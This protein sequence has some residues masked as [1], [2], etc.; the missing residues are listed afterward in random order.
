MQNFRK[1]AKLRCHE[2]CEPQ[3]REINVSRK[4][5]VIRYINHIINQAHCPRFQTIPE[6]QALKSEGWE[7]VSNLGFVIQQQ[8]IPTNLIK[9]IKRAYPIM[10]LDKS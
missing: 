7:C 4:F 2:I 5:H 3:N 9:F 1:I 6:I 10:T 8:G